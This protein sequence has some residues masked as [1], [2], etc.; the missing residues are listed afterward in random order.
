MDAVDCG[1]GE[2]ALVRSWIHSAIFL[3]LVIEF[4]QVCGCD[5]GEHFLAQGMLDIALLAILDRRAD[6]VFEDL[7][8]E[9]QCV[10]TLTQAGYIKRTS[11]SEYTAQSKGGQGRKG[12][13][14]RDEDYV[15]DVFTASTHD[16]LFFFTNTGRVYRKSTTWTSTRLPASW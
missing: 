7:I 8:E 15:S 11:A 1:A 4:S 3:Q 13:T 12:I 6:G 9:Q 14:T 2:P 5:L 10:F 16:Y